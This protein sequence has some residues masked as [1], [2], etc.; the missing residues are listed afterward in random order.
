MVRSPKRSLLTASAKRWGLRLHGLPGRVASLLSLQVVSN[1]LPL[2][3]VP[4]MIRT[5]G[6][7]GYGKVGVA[8]AVNQYLLLIT[9][10]GFTLSA[11]R[12]AA[13]KQDNRL[14]LSELFWNVQSAKLLLVLLALVVLI[15]AVTFVPLFRDEDQLIYLG[16]VIVLG[17]FLSP[18]WLFLGKDAMPS[19]LVLYLLPRLLAIPAIFV[20][21]RGPGDAPIAITMQGVPILITGVLACLY[22]LRREWIEPSMPNWSNTRAQLRKAWPLFVA[23]VS[24]SLYGTSTPIVLGILA[25][26][27]SVGAFVAAEKIKVAA[28]SL[29]TPVTQ[30]MFPRLNALLE[31]NDRNRALHNMRALLVVHGSVHVFIATLL[32]TFAG[33]ITHLAYGGSSPGVQGVLMVLAPTVLIAVLNNVLGVNIML[34]LGMSSSYGRALLIGGVWHICMVLVM[35]W[36]GAAIG[37][38]IATLTTE[39]VILAGLCYGLSRASAQSVGLPGRSSILRLV[40]GREPVP[41]VE[42]P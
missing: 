14:A 28:L 12:E 34:V 42:S 17:N 18:V 6:L 5:L 22:A 23:S 37:A 11:S 9:E 21:V 35:A 33:P 40:T 25:G 16:F 10:Y 2:V 4:Y 39:F 19:L 24:S 20:L 36:L 27:S 41:T 7:D 13:R 15:L 8:L 1:L 29:V 32:L 26:P 38:A 3:T 31:R 30:V